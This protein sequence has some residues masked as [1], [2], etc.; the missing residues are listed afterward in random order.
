MLET[1]ELKFRSGLI[2]NQDCLVEH[3]YYVF[4]YVSFSGDIIFANLFI[5]L[6]IVS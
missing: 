3:P 2:V 4:V 1:H 5:S 6:F